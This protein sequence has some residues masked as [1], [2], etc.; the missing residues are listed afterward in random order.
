MKIIDGRE[1][2]NTLGAYHL[3]TRFK[4][5]GHW[6]SVYYS[7]GSVYVLEQ[8]IAEGKTL[9]CKD[10]IEGEY[11]GFGNGYSGLWVDLTHTKEVNLEDYM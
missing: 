3:G 6:G 11:V 7:E 5:V 1:L 2:R 9:I 10:D 4:C 8:D